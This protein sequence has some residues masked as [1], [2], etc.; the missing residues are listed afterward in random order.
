MKI[1]FLLTGEGTSDLRLQSHIENILIQEGFAEVHG[2]APDLGM[3]TPC[4]GLSVKEKLQALVKHFP[5]TDV[6][7][8]H[9]DADGVGCKAREKE[10]ED[11][12]GDIFEVTRVV[13]IVPLRMLETWLLA[14]ANAIKKVAGNTDQ[15]CRIECLPAPRLLENVANTKDLLLDALCEAS[16]TEG[17]KL[18]KFKKRFSEM[19]ARLVSDLDIDG[20]VRDLPSYK[21][22]RE[23]VSR[24]AQLKLSE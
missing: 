10:I 1:S 18:K 19:R 16:K 9:R 12:V 7:F 21:S 15:R 3:I 4:V 24:Y 13:P 14:D 11:A 6:I 5:R 20:P 23:H 8:V 22:F 17:G 2:E